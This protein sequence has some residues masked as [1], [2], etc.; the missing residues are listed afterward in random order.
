MTLLLRF[1][2]TASTFEE[3]HRPSFGCFCISIF[4]DYVV[5]EKRR[6]LPGWDPPPIVGKPELAPFVLSEQSLLVWK[7]R[8]TILRRQIDHMEKHQH[9]WGHDFTTFEEALVFE[10]SGRPQPLLGS[11]MPVE[12]NKPI[13]WSGELPT[14][15]KVLQNRYHWLWTTIV[16]LGPQAF[17][18]HWAQADGRKQSLVDR[19]S[20]LWERES[21]E[22]KVIKALVGEAFFAARTRVT[23]TVGRSCHLTPRRAPQPY[24]VFHVSRK[25]SEM[26]TLETPRMFAHIDF[27]FRLQPNALMLHESDIPV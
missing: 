5:M 4:A 24:T 19:I 22:E 13:K 3:V 21:F 2:T 27:D 11:R 14:A 16:D 7:R 23:K 12:I 6:R 15:L 10:L 1:Q 17:W 18:A 25:P 9:L 8:W 26:E 20:S